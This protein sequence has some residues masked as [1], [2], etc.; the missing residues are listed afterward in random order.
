MGTGTFNAIEGNTSVS[1]NSNG[2]EVMRRARSTPQ[3]GTVFV[4][5][6]EP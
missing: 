5:V 6:S 4:R 2:G 1:N 3:Q